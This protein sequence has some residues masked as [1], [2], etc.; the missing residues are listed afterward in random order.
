MTCAAGWFNKNRGAAFGILF[1]GSSLGGIIF[2]IMVSRLIGEVGFPWAMR[3]CGF[4]ILALLVITNLTVRTFV[5]PTPQPVTVAQLVKPLKEADFLFVFASLLFYAYGFFIPVNYLP[6]QALSVGMSASLTQYLVAI[7]NTG[8]LFGR[9]IAGF[10]ADKIGK[11]NTFILASYISGIWVLALWIPAQTEAGIT[12]FAIL[13]GAFSGVFIAL[14]TPLLLAISPLSELG[15]RSGMVQFGIAIAGLTGNPI[16]GAIL[17]SAGGW[18]G[19]KVFSGVMCIVGTAFVHVVRV[20]RA[21]WNITA[22][23]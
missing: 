17:D 15:F 14:I 22:V 8:S 19:V 6:T 23:Y 13:M 12:A 18:T 11:Y 16:A 20:K 7:F 9:L 2:P 3:T 1:T 4:L 5:P 10:V 21:G